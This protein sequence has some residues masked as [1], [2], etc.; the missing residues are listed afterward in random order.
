MALNQRHSS[1][2]NKLNKSHDIA[3]ILQHKGSVVSSKK[4]KNGSA[5]QTKIN[6]SVNA[7]SPE[8]KMWTLGDLRADIVKH[9]DNLKPEGEFAKRQENMWKPGERAPIVKRNDNLKPG[10][11][12]QVQPVKVSLQGEMTEKY[13]FEQ[14]ITYLILKSCHISFIFR[15]K[16]TFFI[17]TYNECMC[18]C[19]IRRK[20]KCSKTSR[21]L[22]NRGKVFS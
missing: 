14:L 11:A 17:Y 8:D 15:I 5:K 7:V 10:G 19:F 18:R 12:F 21:Q 16:R 9:P 2:T 22:T 6:Q 13:K 1:R 3:D 4:P 20:S